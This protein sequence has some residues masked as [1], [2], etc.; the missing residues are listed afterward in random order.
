MI[1]FTC[2]EKLWLCWNWFW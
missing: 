1:R 2:W